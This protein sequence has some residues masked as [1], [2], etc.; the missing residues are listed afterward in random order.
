M[1]AV[2][3]IGLTVRN[4]D[5][6][7]AFYC[8]VLG[9]SV[10]HEPTSWFEG[11]ELARAVGVPGASLRLAIVTCGGT[12]IELIEY[13][14]PPANNA[15]PPLS[16]ELGASHVALWVDDIVAK[17][18]E[19]EAR[20]LHFFTEVNVVDDGA[21]AGWRWV[22]FADPDGYPL[23]LVQVAYAHPEERTKAIRSYLASRAPVA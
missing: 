14:S 20:G 5:R 21:L 19:L 13:R 1:K 18:S 16:N 2:H 3:H 22:Y 9:F 15:R 12:A 8:D 17:K 6:S 4:L 7:I 10:I 11:P 23:E